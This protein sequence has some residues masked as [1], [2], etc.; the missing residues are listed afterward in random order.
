MVLVRII[1]ARRHCRPRPRDP[2]SHESVTHPKTKLR[3]E[4]LGANRDPTRDETADGIMFTITME[5]K[6]NTITTYK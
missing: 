2:A 4:S 5:V 1:L 3:R 6:R